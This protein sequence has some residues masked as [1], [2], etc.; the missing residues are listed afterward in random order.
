MRISSFL[1][2]AVIISL[3]GYACETTP[4]LSGAI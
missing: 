3:A 4:N 1:I 2:S